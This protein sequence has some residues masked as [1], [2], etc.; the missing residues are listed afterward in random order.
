[1]GAYLLTRGPSIPSSVSSTTG[2]STTSLPSQLTIDEFDPFISVDPGVTIDLAGEEIVANTNLPL[3]FFDCNCPR[4]DGYMPVLANSWQRS[5]D[6]LTYTFNLR[7]GIHFSNGNPLNAYVVWYNVYRNMFMNQALDSVYFVY[8]NTTGVTVDDLN[9]FNN[10]S[11]QPNAALLQVMQNPHNS[12][13]VLNET[14][15]EF[16]LT[17]PF[18]GLLPQIAAGPPWNF[19]DPYTVEQHGGV[20]ADQPN[21]WMAANGTTVSDGP[22]VMQS[23]VPDQYVILVANP[24]YWAQDLTSSERNF[25]LQA[26]NIATIVINYKADELTRALDLNNNRAQASV[27]LYSDIDSV[28]AGDKNVYIPHTGNTGT[29]EWLALNTFKFPFNNRLVRQAV[30]ESINVTEIQQLV[31]HGYIA[32]LNGPVLHGYFG[33]D[34]SIQAP[35][36][37]VTDA[38]RLLA[39]AG[40]PNGQGLPQITYI[41]FNSQAQSVLSEILVNDLSQIGITVVPEG[42]SSSAAISLFGLPP[43]D[44]KAPLILQETWT[45]WP[46]FT[47]YEFV[48]D[49]DLGVFFDFNNA[50]I[51]DLIYQSNVEQDPTARGH[52]LSQ[53][54]QM[55]NEQAGFVWLGQ[56]IDTFATGVGNGP[57]AWNNCLTGMFENTG[58]IG[59]DFAAIS[60]T[61]NPS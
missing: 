50:T 45:Y 21:A 17:T 55:T 14:A 32:P 41:Y 47:A 57:I 19:A 9:S 13:T 1:M 28:L 59:I 3:I 35:P 33:Y 10:P 15:F 25:M 31:Y 4:Y 11:N 23:Y 54:V 27:L 26:P 44:P 8:A 53:I 20:V 58:F 34:S 2:T 5:S 16:H 12:V 38:K 61:C 30:V 42:L 56:D 24:D 49:A 7:S 51:N 22:Y 60:Y 37:N 29:L 40:Y 6:G 36:Y 18:V 52:M 46:D 48:I 43:T 39:E